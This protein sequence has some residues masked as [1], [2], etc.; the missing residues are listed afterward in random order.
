MPGSTR[1]P[2]S[3]WAASA[4]ERVTVGAKRSTWKPLLLTVVVFAV[5]IG[6]YLLGSE[7]AVSAD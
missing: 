3:S 4:A 6:L 7:L 5:L 2:R 1:R